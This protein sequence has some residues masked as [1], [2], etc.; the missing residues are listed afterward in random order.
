MPINSFLSCFYVI[1]S[2][3]KNFYPSP[4]LKSFFVLNAPTLILHFFLCSNRA[5]HRRKQSSEKE[6]LKRKKSF[7]FRETG[8]G[9]Q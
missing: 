3:L 1:W 6:E 4:Q 8:R 5:V 9:P 7:L 2:L